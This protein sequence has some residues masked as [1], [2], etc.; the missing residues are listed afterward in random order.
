MASAISALKRA[1]QPSPELE[2]AVTPAILQN[3]LTL[4]QGEWA[5]ISWA[6]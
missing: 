1:R 2:G 4:R 5:C 6:S 3:S